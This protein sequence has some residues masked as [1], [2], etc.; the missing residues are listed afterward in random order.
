M[1]LTVEENRQAIKRYGHIKPARGKG[2][3]L[4]AAK[5]PGT[6]R[7]CTLSRDHRGPHVAHGW[8]KRVVAVWDSGAKDRST[9]GLERATSGTAAR[10]DARSKRPIGLR[11]GRPAG[12][13]EPLKRRLL[14]I[15]SSVEQL[16]FVILFIAF[17]GFAIHWIVL[18]AGG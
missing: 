12:V 7:R 17:V 9:T 3:A 6:T 14:D 18:M 1:R 10:R 16:V 15:V 13:L 2:A 5:C 8:F 11:V 4:C